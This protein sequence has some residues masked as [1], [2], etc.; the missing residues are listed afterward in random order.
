MNVDCV[1]VGRVF[2]KCISKFV[3]SHAGF[4]G[5]GVPTLCF[6]FICLGLVDYA[7]RVQSDITYDVSS[8]TLTKIAAS[9]NPT[10]SPFSPILEGYLVLLSHTAIIPY[11][12]PLI[13]AA[14]HLH[15]RKFLPRNDCKC[16]WLLRMADK[17]IFASVANPQ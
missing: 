7:K 15:F 8:A 16:H 13:K 1:S 11:G 17:Y 2:V 10:Y 4:S 6:W 3:R 5:A 12:H 9:E 14:L